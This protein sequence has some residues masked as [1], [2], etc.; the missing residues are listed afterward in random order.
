M[1]NTIVPGD[2]L[3]GCVIKVWSGVEG[4]GW[5]VHVE[6]SDFLIGMGW[7]YPTAQAAWDAARSAWIS[8]NN[9]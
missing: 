6:E 1:S 4:Y 9:G 8:Y 7:S 5:D 2:P 3:P